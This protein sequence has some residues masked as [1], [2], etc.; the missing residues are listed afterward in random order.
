MRNRF[1]W[2]VLLVLVTLLG[3]AWIAVNR[4]QVLE[5][6]GV[7]NLTEAPLAGYLAPDFTLQTIQGESVTLSDLRGQ[8]VI[9][10]FWA[11][12]CPPCRAEM[13]DFQS[14]HQDY[15]GRVTLLGVNQGETAP[16]ITTFA[17]EVGITYPMLVDADSAVNQTYGI[18]AL[19]TT[20]FVDA[21][22]VVREVYSGIL[23][24]AILESRVENLLKEQATGAANP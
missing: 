12:W 1:G 24:K 6:S 8:P 15:N 10:N 2:T 20:I 4:E 9:V 3:S 11:T 5:F 13:P 22:G 16:V 17:A 14:V 18:R 21:D 23:N 7:P 19:P